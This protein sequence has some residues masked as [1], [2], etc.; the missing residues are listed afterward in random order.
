MICY[1]EEGDHLVYLL[2]KICKAGIT[3]LIRDGER[4]SC[5]AMLFCFALDADWNDELAGW[6]DRGRKG[7]GNEYIYIQL[8]LYTPNDFVGRNK[9]INFSIATVNPILTQPRIR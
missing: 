1:P 7:K 2:K 4:T 5:F 6:K 3:F 9:E 8:G